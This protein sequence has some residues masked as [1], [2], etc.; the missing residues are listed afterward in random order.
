MIAKDLIRTLRAH[1]GRVYVEVG[2]GNDVFAVEAVKSDLIAFVSGNF[3]SDEE[4]GF[5]LMKD[6]FGRDYNDR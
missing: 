6:T 3:L 4:T 5:S 1:R 2:N